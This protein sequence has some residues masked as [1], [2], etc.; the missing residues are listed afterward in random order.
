M[1]K[2][3]NDTNNFALLLFVFGVNFEYWDPFGLQGVFSISKMAAIIYIASW[4]PKI[5]QI[6][7]K[8]VNYFLIPLIFYLLMEF[9]SSSINNIYVSSILGTFNFKLAQL[10][11][12]LVL[13]VNHLYNS[14]RMLNYVLYAFIINILLLSILSIFGIG[15]SYNDNATLEEGRL[16]MFGENPNII[17][18]KASLALIMVF[19]YFF[20]VKLKLKIILVVVMLPLL[21]MLIATASR[22]ALLAMF[23]GLAILLLIQQLTLVKKI[24]LLGLG[25]IFSVWLFNYIMKSDELFASR[26]NV[27]LEEGNT[28]RNDLWE[29]AVEIIQDHFIIGVGRQGA[30]PMM[31]QYIGRAMDPHNVFLYV[32]MTTGIIGFTFFMTF[33]IRLMYRLYLKFKIDKNPLFLVLFA[34]LLF[35]MSKAGGF[36]GSTFMWFLSAILI[37]ASLHSYNSK[38]NENFIRN[39]S[40]SNKHSPQ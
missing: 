33:I 22:G 1:N 10:L 11:L 6:S 3:I 30:L 32:L 24:V 15:I 37:G 5:K 14:P 16:R 28:G 35:N 7:F 21:S 19:Y 36:I 4:V 39:R 27:F 29:G 25:I 31:R 13:I 34:I 26:M 8:Q 12:I 17:G 9:F 2:F 20:E 38:S 40:L 18:L 23:F